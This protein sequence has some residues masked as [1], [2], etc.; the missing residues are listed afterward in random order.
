MT[1]HS[2]G[3]LLSPRS[4]AFVGASDK[5]NSTGKAMLEMSQIDGFKGHVYS[6]NPRLTKL[7]GKPC[8]SDLAALPEVPD[9]VVIGVAS[10]FVESILDQAIQLGISAATI[11]ASCYLDKDESPNLPTRITRKA[12]SAGMSICGANCM[13]F[14]SPTVGLRIAS[15]VSPKGLS[16]GGI[17][18]I[19]QSGSA[20][21]A[22][23][24]NDRR[25]GFTL[26]VST[27]MELVTTVVDYIDW[28]LCHPETR[29]IGLFVET[30]RDPAGFVRV[31][32][33]AQ[34]RGIPVV[35][36][37]VG[38]TLRS[39]QMAVSHTGALAGNDAVYEAVFRAYGVHRVGDMDEMAA[40]LALFD[41]PRKPAHGRLGTVHD[42]GGERELIVDIAEDY[43][44]EFAKLKPTT[45][46]KLEANLE[47]GLVAENPL[48][49]FGTHND[50]ER[51][52][53][54]L[55]EILI[56]DPNV[57]IGLFMSN[58]RDGYEY[59]ESY[60]RA[61]MKA[62]QMTEKPLALVSNYSLTDDRDLAIRLKEA[63]VPLLR[64]TR[65]ALLAVKHV[66]DH[67]YFIG[68]QLQSCTDEPA[69]ASVHYNTIKRWRS[70]IARNQP[71]S[72]I[73]G[74]AML[75][76]FGIV[77]PRV[78]SVTSLD[79][80][81]ATLS[82]LNFPL[83]IKTAEDHNHKS[84]V[85][86][87]K[88]NIGDLHEACTVY[89]EM[90][91]RLGPKAL[92][93]EM[94]PSGIE[95]SMGSIYDNGFGPV[96]I[97]SAGGVMVE[98]LADKVAAL[99]PI[100]AVTAKRMLGELRISRLFAGY[101]GQSATNEAAI[102]TQIVRF[103]EMV[104]ALDDAISEIDVN[105]MICGVDGSYAVDCLVV[106]GNQRKKMGDLK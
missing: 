41:N 106:G 27:G 58:P 23:P 9:H 84:D 82:F 16:K 67:Q 30:I 49:A 18:W 15:A 61:V 95:L 1:Q 12:Q 46:S 79:E 17:A 65:N 11:F 87:V 93:M 99:A 48:D 76:D 60:S 37:K 33:T 24:N 66:M 10:R 59:A 86:G 38:R 102:V 34:R 92:V 8:Y 103:S 40:T 29:V 14:Y 19:A 42:S 20:F 90:S 97:L 56:N 88:L 81:E 32:A 73:D 28:A 78:A 50:F 26:A 35:I 69:R 70:H 47:P 5:P 25:L 55:V 7:F 31:L 39:A 91:A 45:C 105:P 94:V 51:R 43:G 4:I 80:L 101:R 72:E 6:V 2:L 53:A 21:S 13:G 74:L 44:I 85:S 71:I 98:F 62:A 36:L 52:L 63:G 57:G 100:N 83:V 75:S 96:I 22:L 64:G 3:P 54:T 104:I 89:R 77:T 68:S